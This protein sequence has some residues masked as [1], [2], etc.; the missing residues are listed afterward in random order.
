M[1]CYGQPVAAPAQMF[2]LPGFTAFDAAVS[3]LDATIRDECDQ[4]SVYAWNDDRTRTV[5]EV[6]H[7]LAEV[8]ELYGS[9]DSTVDGVR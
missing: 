8:A 4:D 1:V 3:Y 6:V 2:E 5:D 7:M 9:G